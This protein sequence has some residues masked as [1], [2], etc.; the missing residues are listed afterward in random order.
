MWRVGKDDKARI[1]KDYDHKLTSSAVTFMP[2]HKVYNVYIH[3][4]FNLQRKREE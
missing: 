3:I 1:K 4:M 2:G